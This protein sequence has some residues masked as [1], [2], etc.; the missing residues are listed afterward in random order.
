MTRVLHITTFLQGGAGR[1]ITDL[2]LAQHRGGYDVLVVADAGGVAGYSSYAE[3]VSEL[4]AAGVPF[5]VLRW[6]F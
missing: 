5:V 6:S 2:A 4:D 1:N 3:Y